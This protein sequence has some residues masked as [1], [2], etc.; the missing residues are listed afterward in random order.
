MV[1]TIGLLALTAASIGFIHTLFG[2]DH[3]LPF[4]MMSRAGN[5]SMKKTAFVT[6]LC[7]IGHVLGSVV[8]GLIGIALGVAVSRLEL[9][10]GVRGNLAAWALIAFGLVYMIWGIR[11]ALKH[12]GHTHEHFDKKKTMTVWVLFTIFVLGPCEPLIPILMYPAYESSL[13]GVILVATIFAIATIGT[14]LFMVIYLSLG[15]KRLKFEKVEHW[16]HAI[17]GAVILLSGI[18][19]QFLG[20]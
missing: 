6:F 4:I 8:L 19:I 5:W 17:A 15:L 11:R 2:P 20:L 16:T 10:E 18:G 3:Y 13:I 1:E 7:G 12:K 14:M 9:F